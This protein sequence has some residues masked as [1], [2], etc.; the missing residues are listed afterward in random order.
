MATPRKP[1][2]RRAAGP[3]SSTSSASDPGTRA[4]RFV[5]NLS[6]TGDFLGTPF[7]LRPWQE[8]ILRRLFGTLRPDG[9]RRYRKAFLALPRK[10]GKTELAAAILLYL[11]LGTGKRGQ[12]LYSASGDRAQAS[13]IFKAAASM[14]RNDPE[15]ERLCQVYDGYKKIVCEPL[16]ST[17]E[18]LSSD[19]PRKH[20]L[21]PSAVLF[22]EV[23]VLPNR[24]LHDV[25][26]TGFAARREQLTLYI[27]TAG[28][29]RHSL[30]HELW[31]YA[32]HVRDGI[33]QDPTF[34]PVLYA[35]AKDDDWADEATWRKAMPALGDFCS[36]ET[37]RDEC[38]KAQNLPSYEN[39]FRQLYLNQ[40]TEQASR[41]LSTDRW[42]ACGTLDP[43]GMAALLDGRECF[44]GLDL[45]V[46]G[47]MSALCT[48]TPNDLGGFDLDWRYWVPRDGKWRQ[49]KDNARQYA[50]WEKQGRLSF[51]EGEA[52]D[53]DRVE[54]DILELNERRPFRLLCADRAYATMLLS[55][56]F[57]NFGLPVKGIAQ[58]PVTLNEPM[59]R[60]ESMLL[61]GQ[62][63]HDG[64]PVA[65]WNAA[66]ASV[67][68]TTT[69]LMHLDKSAAT[70]RIDGLAAAID[71][72]AGAA[73]AGGLSAPAAPTVEW[74]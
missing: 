51:T 30:C 13:L 1:R 50:L 4:V 29:D 33:I 53:F 45:G 8:S 24:E 59:V 48:A 18:A 58:G 10:Q 7:E 46:T 40:W 28:W 74:I 20:G 44:A 5:N 62:L 22:D 56:L 6:H 69:G 15:L 71:A 57:H 60:L 66:N 42:A 38:R 11:L 49:E 27:T 41:W 54:A 67:I 47:D 32:E 68:R 36:L 73:A 25:L 64:H 70:R 31:E 19:A 34:L 17:Y 55:R 39:T 2:P 63:R 21:G 9:L 52:T 16:D 35:A 43:A 14:V 12:M 23:H 72:L 37:I 3:A 61:D 26:T 65:A